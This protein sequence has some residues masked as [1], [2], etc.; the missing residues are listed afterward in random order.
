M[1]RILLSLVLV[2]GTLPFYVP[3]PA[4]ASSCS[5]PNVFVNGSVADATQVNANFSSLVNC[6]NNIDNTNIGAN[7]IYASQI[8]PTSSGQAT[9]GGTQAYTFANGLTVNGGLTLGSVLSIANGGTGSAT[10]NLTA[11]S[12]ISV[13]GTWPNQTIAFT[14]VLPIASGGTGSGSQNFVD[15]STTQSIGGA[16]SF[17]SA[18]QALSSYVPPVYTQAGATVASTLHAVLGVCNAISTTC[19]VTLSGAATFTNASSYQC[20]ITLDGGSATNGFFPISA[21]QFQISNTL[22]A[23]SYGWFCI[24]T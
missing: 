19:T 6:G 7:G 23:S 17:T 11:G 24:G 1:R 8:K 5:V 12:N 20:F 4:Y 13:T 21:T 9:F 14:G 18:V 3:L 2:L 16:K 10:A 22:N 15:L